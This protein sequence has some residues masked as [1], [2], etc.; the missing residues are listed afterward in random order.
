MRSWRRDI[1]ISARKSRTEQTALFRGSIDPQYV[2]ARSFRRALTLA[3][4]RSRVLDTNRWA[5]LHCLAAATAVELP[6]AQESVF[7]TEDML[8]IHCTRK[9]LASRS[10]ESFIAVHK[11]WKSAASLEPRRLSEAKHAW[12]SSNNPWSETFW[13]LPL[14]FSERNS[15]VDGSCERLP[16]PLCPPSHAGDLAGYR[17]AM[18]IYWVS[19]D[20]LPS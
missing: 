16:S 20:Q 7:E 19:L 9:P 4:E 3:D 2:Q 6:Q 14:S 18:K 11:P 1:D 17:R 8:N 10:M 5:L 12:W 13:T 15:E